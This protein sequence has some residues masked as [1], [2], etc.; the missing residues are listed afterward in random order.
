MVEQALR[1]GDW[2]AVFPDPFTPLARLGSELQ[3]GTEEVG[4][5]AELIGVKI[6]HQL[7]HLGVTQS[8]IAEQLTHTRPVLLLDTRVVV[9]V[10]GP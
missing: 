3:R 9:R 1:R 6:V 8:V 7:H 2:L 5:Q 4:E 10:V